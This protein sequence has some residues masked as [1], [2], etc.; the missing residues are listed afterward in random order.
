[1]ELQQKRTT[2]TRCKTAR[3]NAPK[4]SK[5]PRPEINNFESIFVFLD[6]S[7]I[8]FVAGIPTFFGVCILMTVDVNFIAILARVRV[9]TEQ[10]L[11]PT[12]SPE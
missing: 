9:S 3:V 10:G 1:M 4:A 2:K 7:K 8:Y 12:F 11:S 6:R 5:K